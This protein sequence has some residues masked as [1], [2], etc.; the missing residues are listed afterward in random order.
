MEQDEIKKG[1]RKRRK[2]EQAEENADAMGERD[3]ERERDRARSRPVARAS[4]AMF[5]DDPYRVRKHANADTRRDV[6]TVE[7]PSDRTDRDGMTE[8]ADGH[9]LR[10]TRFHRRRSA[11]LPSST[12]ERWSD[13]ASNHRDDGLGDRND[14]IDGNNRAF[15]V[16]SGLT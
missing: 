11:S 3:K 12:R 10:V 14:G 4:M 9:G 7:S 5:P 6:E 8:I 13:G 16:G 2:K 1:T 15:S